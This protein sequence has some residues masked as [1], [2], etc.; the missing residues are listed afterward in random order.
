MKLRFSKICNVLF[1]LYIY[2]CALATL[3]IACGFVY[4]VYLHWTTGENILLGIF[5]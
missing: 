1:W 2:A 3:I 4:G 5:K